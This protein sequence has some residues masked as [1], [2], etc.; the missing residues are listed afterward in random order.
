MER[1]EWSASDTLGYLGCHS[2]TRIQKGRKF[3]GHCIIPSS[4][5]P[6]SSFQLIDFHCWL[7]HV[8][9]LLG[10]HFISLLL[11]FFLLIQHSCV[12][13]CVSLPLISIVFCQQS[14]ILVAQ[15]AMRLGVGGL[16]TQWIKLNQS[17]FTA[18]TYSAG[19]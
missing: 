5:F 15:W 1:L 2:Q 14:D 4:I 6:A 19:T 16:G 3:I 7:N 11:I 10:G 13:V 8:H 18:S 9:L 12:C 17:I